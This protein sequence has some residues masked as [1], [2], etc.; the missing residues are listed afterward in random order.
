MLNVRLSVDHVQPGPS[1][2]PKS[3]HRV[4]KFTKTSP[5][6]SFPN[7]NHI[8]MTITSEANDCDS[9]T[10]FKTSCSFHAASPGSH[11]L[12]RVT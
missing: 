10:C 8:A 9:R 12:S 11:D 5:V 2:V 1:A 6:I 3:I 4:N 7:L